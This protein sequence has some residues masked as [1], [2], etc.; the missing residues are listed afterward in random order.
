MPAENRI[1][2][3]DFFMKKAM[4]GLMTVC[5][6]AGI[7]LLAGCVRERKPGVD[8]KTDIAIV[9]S[10]LKK[11][12]RTGDPAVRIKYLRRAHYIATELEE[13]WPD[14]ERVPE[15][16]GKRGMEIDRIPQEVY[17]LAMEAR[18]LDSFKWA[19]S[20]SARV[21][22]QFNDFRRVWGMG[23]RWRDYFIEEYPGRA[24]PLFMNEAIGDRNTKFFDEYIGEFRAGGYR[25]VFPLDET[26]FMSQLCGFIAEMLETAM[27]EK[28]TE[29]ITF[30]LE[31]MPVYDPEINRDPE[32]LRTM[33]NL[34][35][36]VCYD[37]KDEE[38]AC[39]LVTLRYEMVRVD[40]EETGFGSDFADVLLADLDYAVHHVLKLNEWHGPLSTKELNFVFNLPDPL[41]RTIHKLH[42]LEA[43]EIAL[44]NRN[45]PELSRLIRA[46][47]EVQPLTLSDYDRLLGWSIEYRNREVYDYVLKNLPKI[48]I[49]NI[50]LVE[51]GKTPTLFR[52]HAPKILRD[53]QPTMDRQP[54]NGGTTLGRVDDLLR[55][56]NP[57]AVL[58]VVQKY[59]LEKIWSKVPMEGRTVLMSVCEGGNLEAAKY[60]I[61]EKNASLRAVTHYS[62]MENTIF[63][64]ARPEEGKLGPIHFAAMSGNGRLIEYLKS[65]G[66]DVNQRSV[67]G[68]TPLMIAVSNQQVDAA[69]TLLALGAD[70]NA[71]MDSRLGGADLADSGGV[72]SQR[73]A[74]RRAMRTGNREIL[75]ILKKNGAKP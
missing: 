1:I 31:Q 69:R 71:Q 29:R 54:W 46:R 73:T 35:E 45:S 39:R 49:Y 28:D 57:E 3:Q 25:L 53:I 51:L 10:S 74:Y 60:L 8:A 32:T 37:L 44:K 18:D 5:L 34:S 13:N 59:D 67:L 55:S 43:M 17:E 21:D 50:S 33:R 6:S 68:T 52:L 11:A 22:L 36:F 23:K 14:S 9:K 65:K 26:E 72:E 47:E 7:F 70:V 30:L 75:E 24:L 61:E 64:R 15:F 4:T 12:G 48:D 19:V 20:Q 63:G 56:R 2:Y 27:K 41:L 16:L 38:L 62:E 58:Y 42:L 40:V 66:A